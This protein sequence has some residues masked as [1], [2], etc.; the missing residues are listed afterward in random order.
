MRSHCTCLLHLVSNA[1][2]RCVAREGQGATAHAQRGLQYLVR[3]SVCLSVCLS[4]GDLLRLVHDMTKYCRFVRFVSYRH[5]RH[6]MNAHRMT[7]R[8]VMDGTVE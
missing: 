5:N 8:F 2:S 7:K 6:F 1:Q 3:M 4:V